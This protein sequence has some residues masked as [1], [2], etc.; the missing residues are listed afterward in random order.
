M[1]MRIIYTKASLMKTVELLGH[2]QDGEILDLFDVWNEE[3]VRSVCCESNV[4]IFVVNNLS[5]VGR[6]RRVENRTFRQGK[7]NSLKTA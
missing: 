7:R 6:E 5:S 1:F 4:V 3:A 2:F